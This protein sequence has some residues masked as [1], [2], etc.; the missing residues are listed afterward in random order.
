MISFC[1]CDLQ[2]AVVE[3]IVGGKL[4]FYRVKPTKL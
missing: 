2:K 3:K 4:D 1:L